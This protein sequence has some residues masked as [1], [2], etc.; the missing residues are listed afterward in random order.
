MATPCAC[1]VRCA[2][3]RR[4]AY[5][6]Q[7]SGGSKGE[8]ITSKKTHTILVKR[9]ALFSFTQH[10][11]NCRRSC[12]SSVIG[13]LQQGS[14]LLDL[15]N[16]TPN[17]KTQPDTHNPATTISNTYSAIR[18]LNHMPRIPIC[19]LNKSKTPM[20]KLFFCCTIP[21]INTSG[22][23]LTSTAFRPLSNSGDTIRDYLQASTAV[24]D[25]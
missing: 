14:R 17:H 3:L 6:D 11:L 9:G 18:L 10:I 19:S 4:G 20:D 12:F 16:Q 1:S 25:N 22:L 7:S 13:L 2:R 8:R 21:V 15:S 23:I 24:P 5:C